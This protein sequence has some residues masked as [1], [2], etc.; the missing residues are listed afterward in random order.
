MEKHS[1][2]FR[3]I[4]ILFIS[5]LLLFGCS[6]DDGTLNGTPDLDIKFDIT[7]VPESAGTVQTSAVYSGF[8]IFGIELTAIPSDGFSFSHWEG[9]ASFG[10]RGSSM[11]PC[12]YG[13]NS[14]YHGST[15]TAKATAVFEEI[16]E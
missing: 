13:V 12:T 10:C 14:L 7:I 15:Y 11:N 6:K 4:A 5:S 3:S 16:E 9:T 8:G 2:H 1:Y